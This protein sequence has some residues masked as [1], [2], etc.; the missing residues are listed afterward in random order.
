MSAT[1]FYVSDE[2][3]A[4]VRTRGPSPLQYGVPVFDA[5]AFT[6]ALRYE[7]ALLR[8]LL[9]RRRAVYGSDAAEADEYPMGH[10]PPGLTSQHQS[11]RE[12]RI[13]DHMAV[14]GPVTPSD[15]WWG[16]FEGNYYEGL[17][18]YR[19]Q[20]NRTPPGRCIDHDYVPDCSEAA[21]GSPLWHGQAVASP[22]TLDL[23]AVMADA[24]LCLQSDDEGAQTQDVVQHA[25]L[26]SPTTTP[27]S[28]QQPPDSHPTR[29]HASLP[30][31][32]STPSPSA[33]QHPSEC[34]TSELED[35]RQYLVC[36]CGNCSAF[37]HRR[38]I[39][40]CQHIISQGSGVV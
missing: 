35:R 33:Q 32:A 10:T 37:L 31:P 11:D 38:R 15:D 14:M 25:S 27:P 34:P 40:L 1:S 7:L 9:E 19:T 4:S 12:N 22:S 18:Y 6:I 8:D 28:D 20:E 5:K 13:R 39:E 17:A 2:Y 30:S 3:F 26:P 29:K 24:G 36:K 21:G 16:T 23:S